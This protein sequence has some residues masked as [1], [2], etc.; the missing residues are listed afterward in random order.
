MGKELHASRSYPGDVAAAYTPLHP[1]LPP[2]PSRPPPGTVDEVSQNGMPISVTRTDV[3]RDT[4]AGG[5]ERFH[6]GDNAQAFCPYQ[7]NSANGYLPLHPGTKVIINHVGSASDE[8]GWLYGRTTDQQGK[9]W[10]PSSVASGR[11]PATLAQ[12][13]ERPRIPT[14]RTIRA[15]S[16]AALAL[17]CWFVMSHW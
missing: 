6:E 9:G 16:A 4:S 3:L 5:G 13:K 15:S 1:G 17:C 2:P 11:K 12:G 7:G 14:L 10:F 8:V